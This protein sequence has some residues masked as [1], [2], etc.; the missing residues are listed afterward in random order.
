MHPMKNKFLLGYDL[1]P[2]NAALIAPIVLVA[3]VAPV[4]PI[5]PVAP[6]ST[7]SLNAFNF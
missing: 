5:D 6:E 3:P 1:F 4:A 7:L 2:T